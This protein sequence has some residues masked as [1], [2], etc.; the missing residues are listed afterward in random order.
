MLQTQPKRL[1]WAV[2]IP[3]MMDSLQL[4]GT[5]VITVCELSVGLS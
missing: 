4:Q 1:P 3:A 5:R 2:G